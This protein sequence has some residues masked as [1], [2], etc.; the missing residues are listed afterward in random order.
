V[1]RIDTLKSRCLSFS[2]KT[3]S[4][5]LVPK[6]LKMLMRLAAGSLESVARCLAV[7]RPNPAT[8]A[9]RTLVS[10]PIQDGCTEKMNR[11]KTSDYRGVRRKLNRKRVC[12]I[13]RLECSSDGRLRGRAT[14]FTSV[15]LLGMD[16]PSG[17]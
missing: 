3:T 13:H 12:E 11:A 2:P 15:S 7:F 10:A 5:A 9:S 6:T 8:I 4:V 16:G 17:A 1:Q 14:C